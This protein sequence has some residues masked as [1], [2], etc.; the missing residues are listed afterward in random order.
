MAEMWQKYG[1]N[2]YP[3]NVS[4]QSQV[5][6][7]TAITSR[8]S[9]QVNLYNYT[10]GARREKCARIQAPREKNHAS[11]L[12]RFDLTPHGARVFF[13]LK[14]YDYLDCI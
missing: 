12:T 9:N 1:K 8:L 2:M 10:R 11:T 14:S 5:A 3:L 7:P 4:L 13:K 6:R